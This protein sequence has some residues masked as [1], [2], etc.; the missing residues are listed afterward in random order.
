MPQ[1]V[2]NA[3]T[4]AAAQAAASALN[5]GL[6]K[7]P[8]IIILDS[9]VALYDFQRWYENRLP[10]LPLPPE[11][12]LEGMTLLL[13]NELDPDAIEELSQQ[14]D[15]FPNDPEHF[16]PRFREEPENPARLAELLGDCLI[17]DD[18]WDDE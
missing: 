4:I 10:E 16:E 8:A 18:A 7:Q 6:P 17:Q 5:N 14:L 2:A 12:E 1:I 13:Y 3:D 9:G 11:L 15:C